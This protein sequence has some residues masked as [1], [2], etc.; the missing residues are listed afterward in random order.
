MAHKQP[1]SRRQHGGGSIVNAFLRLSAVPDTDHAPRIAP[2]PREQPVPS[3]RAG[4]GSNVRSHHNPQRGPP[5]AQ[6]ALAVQ[7][8]TSA[9][10]QK[11]V[12]GLP[13]T[14][15]SALVRD[16]VETAMREYQVAWLRMLFLHFSTLNS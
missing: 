3:A 13:C 11:A 10:K 16:T 8:L 14:Q 4:P 12:P 7:A 9:P 5:G 6:T 15:N 1:S 2:R